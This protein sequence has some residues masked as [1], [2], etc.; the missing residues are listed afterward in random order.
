MRTSSPCY[1]RCERS[2]DILADITLAASG[3]AT[4]SPQSQ[5]RQDRNVD[6]NRRRSVPAPPSTSPLS[7]SSG[8]RAERFTPC[9]TPASTRARHLLQK[10]VALPVSKAL[11]NGLLTSPARSPMQYGP[12]R[13]NQEAVCGPTLASPC[14]TS[15]ARFTQTGFRESATGDEPLQA[16]AAEGV[17]LLN[18]NKPEVRHRCDARRTRASPA[19]ATSGRMSR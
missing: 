3:R 8:R 5:R 16:A 13:S 4:D 9:C 15:L 12:P 10:D 7:I 19:P 11:E 17:A 18:D 14:P 1:P 6:Q 2:E